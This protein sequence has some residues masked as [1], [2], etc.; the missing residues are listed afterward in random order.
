VIASAIRCGS[1]AAITLLAGA[2]ADAP[3]LQYSLRTPAVTLHPISQAPVV[4]GRAPFRELLCRL[5]AERA[6]RSAGERPCEQILHR[7]SD[8]PTAVA[9]GEVPSPRSS[10]TQPV[11]TVVFVP[12]LFGECVESV[13][14]P[15]SD[16]YARLRALGYRVHA[17]HLDGRSGSAHNARMLNDAL[18]DIGADEFVVVAY[19]KGVPD[20]L[21]MLAA[22]PETAAK[23]RAV[24]SIAGIVSGTPIADR[25]ASG[26][27]TLDRNVSFPACPQG[28]GDAVRSLT[29][30]TRLGWLA[31][32]RLPASVRIYSLAAFTSTEGISSAILPFHALLSNVDPRNDGFVIYSD[33]V[34][35]GS[36]LLGYVNAD[37][38]AIAL[39][40]RDADAVWRT[41]ASHNDFPREV[42]IESVLQFVEDRL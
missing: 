34:V 38:W 28:D 6:R 19:S 35:P 42:V 9:P 5:V 31:G 14:T 4:D 27:S 13:A 16:A 36:V 1:L 11:P 20:T 26:Y 23:V 41:M 22:F 12:G 24:V 30:E 18:A 37:H 33:A 8:E 10:R 17:A 15:F 2:C 21:E 39:P 25:L 29:R 32:N 7:L 40:L 3:L